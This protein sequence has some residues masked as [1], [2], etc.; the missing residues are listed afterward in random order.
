MTTFVAAASALAM[1]A[2]AAPQAAAAAELLTNGGFEDIGAGATPEGWGGLTYYVDGT[3]PGNVALPGWIVEAGS[4]DLTGTNTTWGPANTGAYSLDING[5]D[6][7]TIAQ[8]FDTVA[9]AL[10]HVS[11]AYSRNAAGA[12][13][14]ATADVAA[15]GGVF[16]VSAANDTSLFGYGGHMLWQAG[17]FDFIG[18]GHDTIRLTA[19]VPGNGGVF[20]DD[21]SVTGPTGAVPEPAAWALMIGGFGMAGAVLRR[22]RTMVV[23]AAA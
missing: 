11:F 21:V 19:T 17:G 12:P 18:A 3:H 14:P 13:D 5:W 2:M 22:R 16:H 6:A 1:L 8:S 10:Y 9:G 15:G 7:G 4:V 23:A 20:F